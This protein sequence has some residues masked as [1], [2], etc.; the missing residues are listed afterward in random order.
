MEALAYIEVAYRILQGEKEILKNEL[1]RET[2]QA[3]MKEGYRQNL[4]KRLENELAQE[5]RKTKISPNN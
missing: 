3:E 2:E 4:L 5:R 1:A